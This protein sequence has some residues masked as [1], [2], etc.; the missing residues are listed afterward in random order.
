MKKTSVTSDEGNDQLSPTTEVPSSRSA[1]I[2]FVVLAIW[3]ALVVFTTTRHEY[4][5][6][7]V[8]AFTLARAATS[9]LDLHE[10]IRDDGHPVLWYVLLY[11]GTSI[12]DTPLVLPI[13]SVL[14]GFAAVA[15]FMW[16]A[17]FPLWLRCVF[18]FS[19]LPLFEYSVM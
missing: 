1:I 17:P 2:T 10:R 4:W 15:V 13:T 3:L 12:V 11:L 9:P 5:R 8:R 19:A 14:I 6:D 18:I 16:F 7:E